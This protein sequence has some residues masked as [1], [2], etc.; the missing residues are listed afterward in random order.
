[1][2][3]ETFFSLLEKYRT[4]KISAAERRFLEKIYEELTGEPPALDGE[5]R[6]LL[7]RIEENLQAAIDRERKEGASGE[8][9][10]LLDMEAVEKR[11]AKKRQ[12]IRWAVAACTIGLLGIASYITLNMQAPK[13]ASTAKHNGADVSPGSYK[14]KLTLA[15]GHTISLDSAGEGRL[16]EQQGMQVTS[17][18]GQLKYEGSGPSNDKAVYNT[19]TTARGETY[20]VRLADGSV[21]TL[22]SGSSVYFPVAFTG[23]ERRITITGEVYIKVAK[24]P[25]QHFIVTANG[26][27]VQALG[28][29]FAINAYPDEKVVRATLVEG[30]VRVTQADKAASVVLA[31]GERADLQKTSASLVVSKDPDMEKTLAWVQNK[32]IFEDDLLPDIM[33]QLARWYDVE[34]VYEGTLK[35]MRFNGVISRQRNASAV[36][37]ML[38]ETNDIRFT[39]EGR[40]IIVTP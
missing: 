15:D 17:L 21:V 1:M 7:S 40:K 23:P 14:A 34:V 37:Q 29:E 3:K 31:P 12:L 18:H 27:D 20:S 4:G 2:K 19:I 39:I 38:K 8:A 9:A 13:P 30:A 26:M 5:S 6:Q 24:N 10:R 35:P 32:F 22:N 11:P 28:T 36:L 16:A 33:R 25:T